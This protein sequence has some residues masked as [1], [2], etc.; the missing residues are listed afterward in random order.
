MTSLKD[1][2]LTELKKQ[3]GKTLSGEA[4]AAQCQ[5]SR[6]AVWKAVQALTAQGCLIEAVPG[7]GYRLL[8][9]SDTL[10]EGEIQA[11]LQ[12]AG[13]ETDV[14]CFSTIDSTNTEARRRSQGLRRPMLLAAEE[15]TAG[16]GRHGHTFYSPDKTG[17]YMTVALPIDLPLQDAALA[18]QAMAVAALR[19]VEEAGGPRLNVKWV[20]DLF[21]GGKKVAGILTEAISD[22]E[23]GRTAALICGI[24]FNLTTEDFP[25]EIRQTA[26][27]IG[28]LDR[29]RL[30][31]E[32]VRFYLPFA[33]ALPD[34]SPWMGTYRQR[35]MVLSHGLSFTQNGQTVHAVAERI[36][37]RGGLVVR[38]A[39]GSE[40][41]LSSGE[42]SIRPDEYI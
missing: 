1:K 39:D 26:G 4:L 27:Q 12:Q 24:G 29:N 15:Q 28:A 31:A 37:D 2:V 10:R 5:V 20:N 8:T 32:V 18:T 16:R 40:R 21:C 9:A 14:V 6:A 23:S 22:L 3:N 13:E 42:I 19:A 30:A 35:S 17:L 11:L 38:L 34:T 25:Q 41:T 36:D 33:R 7:S